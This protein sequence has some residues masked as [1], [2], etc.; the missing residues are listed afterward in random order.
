MYI[1]IPHKSLEVPVLLTMHPGALRFIADGLIRVEILVS[2][3]VS[4][5]LF[6]N[7]L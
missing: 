5:E 3:L 6:R 7:L 1:L 2:R 4:A